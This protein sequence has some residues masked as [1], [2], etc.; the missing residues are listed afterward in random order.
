MIQRLASERRVEISED[1]VASRPAEARR[2]VDLTRPIGVS[3]EI[4]VR[5]RVL[6][7][8]GPTTHEPLP[9]AGE[10]SLM[11]AWPI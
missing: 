4:W 3:R 2:G 7:G 1:R 9:R 10:H 6:G 11:V 8:P 5:D